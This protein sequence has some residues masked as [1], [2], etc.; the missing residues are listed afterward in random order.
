MMDSVWSNEELQFSRDINPIR[1]DCCSINES[2]L[3][4][5]RDQIK[6]RLQVCAAK[7]PLERSGFIASWSC[8]LLQTA[9]R[10]PDF[11]SLSPIVHINHQ[12]NLIKLNRRACRL[13]KPT[14][15]T[16]NEASEETPIDCHGRLRGKTSVCKPPFTK[17]FQTFGH[18]TFVCY[19]C[20]NLQDIRTLEC[21]LLQTTLLYCETGSR[22]PAIEL[23]S[24]PVEKLL[25]VWLHQ[26]N[27]AAHRLT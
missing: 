8:E 25:L 5:I 9:L 6:I 3:S 20:C 2:R 21:R 4:W 16:A 17:L 23:R 13:N 14:Q 27:S 22:A 26:A 12:I 7:N 1:M 19:N 18:T 24:E 11:L 10:P 15:P